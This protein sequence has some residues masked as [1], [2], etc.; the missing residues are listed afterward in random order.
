MNI[1]IG[2]NWQNKKPIWVYSPPPPPTKV[3][4]NQKFDWNYGFVEVDELYHY[5]LC[6]DAKF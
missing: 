2:Q 3:G 4:R 1:L 5:I 6:K